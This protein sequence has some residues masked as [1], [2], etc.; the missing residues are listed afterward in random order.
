MKLLDHPV[1]CMLAQ[2]IVAQPMSRGRFS[3]DLSACRQR[4]NGRRYSVQ[5]PELDYGVESD[6]DWEEP[7]DGEL[8]TVCCTMRCLPCSLLCPTLS[9]GP[10][11]A[12]PYQ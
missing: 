9:S 2:H 6:E 4:V 7:A 10:F 11:T 5:E 8:L 1:D 3:P 12:L